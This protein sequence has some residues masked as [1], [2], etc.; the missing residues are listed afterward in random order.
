MQNSPLVSIICLCYNHAQFVEEALNSVLSQ[1]YNNIELLIADD[2]SPDDS[3]AVIENWL[4]NHPEVIFIANPTNIGNTKTFNKMLALAKGD[5][6][7]DL[8]ADDVLLPDCVEKQ[9]L[10]FENSEFENVGIVYGNA[11]IISETNAHLG[12]YYE[13]NDDGKIINPPP[14]G[15]IYLSVLGQYNKICS[16]S[17]LGKR[18]VFEKLDGYDENLAYED[19]DLWI[20][21]ARIYNFDFIPDVLIMKRELHTSLGAQFFHKN[22]ERTR[23]LNRSTYLIIQKALRQNST[24]EE[25]RALL[26]RI[27]YEMTKVFKARDFSLLLQYI[28]LELKIR[29]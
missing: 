28:L 26:K 5:Y 22:N 19:L 18:E 7:I 17:S 21:A 10:A 24:K 6:I 2:C 29:I 3:K 1:T 11:E 25:N 12:Y 4:T 20:R 14:S 13:L 15:D 9:L 23:K 27:H 8:A 16:V